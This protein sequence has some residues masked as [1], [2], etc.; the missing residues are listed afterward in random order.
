MVP[1]YKNFKQFVEVLA[2]EMVHLWQWQTIEGST[3]NHNTEFHSWKEKFKQ[4]GLNLGLKV[5][6]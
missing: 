6:E 4:N 3:V 5:D 2:H 1:V